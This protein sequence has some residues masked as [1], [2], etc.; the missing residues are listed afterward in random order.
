MNESLLEQIKAKT[1]KE[2]LEIYV[3]DFNY[4]AAF[5]E[6][7]KEE[8][9]R[10]EVPFEQ[11]N[12]IKEK[13]QTIRKSE[14]SQGKQGSPVYIIICGI[15]ALLGGLTGIIGGYIYAYSKVSDVDGMKYHAYDKDTRYWGRIIFFIGIGVLV[16]S[17]LKNI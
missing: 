12:E 6:L 13:K 2:L 9:I 3:N 10:R 7:A 17:V 5:V 1:D 14:L 8:M 16:V 4:Q 11:T 15:L